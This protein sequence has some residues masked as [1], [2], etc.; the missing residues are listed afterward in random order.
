MVWGE[1]IQ[2]SIRSKQGRKMVHGSCGK[3]HRGPF[4]QSLF[5]YTRCVEFRGMVLSRAPRNWW[6]SLFLPVASGV[7][8]AKKG[9]S[10]ASR[11]KELAEILP[12]RLSDSSSSETGFVVRAVSNPVVEW[13]RRGTGRGG[14]V[15]SCRPKNDYLRSA[16]RRLS[17]LLMPTKRQHRRHNQTNTAEE[18]AGGAHLECLQR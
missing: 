2:G 12:R 1:R 15:G 8:N 18:W 17:S 7:W 6:P 3:F 9:P 10:W 13:T 16:E 11:T 4:L 14:G 5:E